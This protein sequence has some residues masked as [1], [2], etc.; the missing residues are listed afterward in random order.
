[1]KNSLIIGTNNVR[2][3]RKEVRKLIDIYL[4]QAVKKKKTVNDW[5]DDAKFDLP[6]ITWKCKWDMPVDIQ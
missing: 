4:E 5:R 6:S 1:M 3:E 2:D